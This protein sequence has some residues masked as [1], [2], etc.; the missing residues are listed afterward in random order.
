L[1]LLK[2]VGSLPFH[3][4]KNNLCQFEQ[5][6]PILKDEAYLSSIY[7]SW[8]DVQNF[9]KAHDEFYV[10]NYFSSIKT[11]LKTNKILT[12][13]NAKEFEAMLK[14]YLSLYFGSPEEELKEKTKKMIQQRADALAKKGLDI[15]PASY[16]KVL[17]ACAWGDVQ[18]VRNLFAQVIT[19][20]RM[21]WIAGKIKAR[22]TSNSNLLKKLDSPQD[23]IRYLKL[24]NKNIIQ[25][26]NLDGWRNDFKLK[27]IGNE[28]ELQSSGA[29]LDQAGDDLIFRMTL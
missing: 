17:V 13:L 14:S 12:E 15:N 25:E 10:H 7:K 5:L 6:M 9:L 19:W 16:N 29:N 2:R 28:I 18:Y 26:S 3:H 11:L 22:L 24:D 23:L 8:S 4:L 1:S 20:Y 21:Q 27:L